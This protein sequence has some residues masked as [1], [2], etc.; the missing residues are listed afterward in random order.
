MEWINLPKHRSGHP[1][2]CLYDK[3]WF[4]CIVNPEGRGHLCYFHVFV[5][6][7]KSIFPANKW[8][9]RTDLLSGSVFFSDPVAKK[10]TVIWLFLNVCSH[11]KWGLYILFI[12][13]LV[14]KVPRHLMVLKVHWLNIF[15]SWCLFLIVL[16]RNFYWLSLHI[17]SS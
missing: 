15:N 7:S 11:H 6:L 4:D 14:L 2:P 12:Y 10:K 3:A 16:T 5:L 13:P 17:C 8:S 1:V 9:N